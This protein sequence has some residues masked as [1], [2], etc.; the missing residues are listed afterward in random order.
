M[1]ANMIAYWHLLYI[2]ATPGLV[3]KIRTEV[4]PYAKVTK[5]ES[6][7]GFTEAPKLA[8]SAD[9]L[10]KKCPLLKATYFETMRL[11]TR[12]SSTRRITADVT[13]SGDTNGPKS[14]SYILHQG[15]YVRISHDLH[16]K[17]PKYFEHPEKFNPERFLGQNKDGTQSANMGTI[18]PYG[19][20]MSACNGQTFA[21]RACLSFVS[22]ILA[23]WDIQPASKAGWVIPKMTLSSTVCRPVNDTRARITERSFKWDS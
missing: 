12:P 13:I 17:D 21:E 9:G 8:L 11:S 19:N 23:C 15:E 18:R 20:G 22:G 14:P 1:N 5:P 7:G 2:L 3:D 10:C 6:I 4:A 16:M